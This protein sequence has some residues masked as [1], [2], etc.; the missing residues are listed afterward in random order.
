MRLAKTMLLA[1]G[2]FWTG[3]AGAQSSG[4]PKASL[5]DAG[6]AAVFAQFLCNTPVG[7]IETFRHKVDSLTQGG[8]TSAAYHAGEAK[9]RSIIE[10]VRR[11]GNG[12]TRELENS[13]CPEAIGLVRKVIAQP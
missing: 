11:T 4:L 10:G 6:Q 1:S 13:T 5:D 7:D 2:I 3:W 12:D 9:A 8:S